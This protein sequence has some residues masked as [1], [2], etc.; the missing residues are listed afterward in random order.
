[1][2]YVLFSV[3]PLLPD[4]S[5]VLVDVICHEFKNIVISPP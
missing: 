2:K 5:F 4:H 3:F 1:M